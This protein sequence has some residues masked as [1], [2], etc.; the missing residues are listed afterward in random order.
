[1]LK[2]PF[3]WFGG[4]SRVAPIVWDRFGDVANYIE[5][6]FGSG[7]VLLGRPH[8]SG[9]TETINDADGFVANAWRAIKTHPDETADFADWPCNEN[10]LTARHIWLVGQ[11]KTLTEKLE[12]DPEYCDPKIAGWW[13]WG[14]AG[15]IG[16]GWCSGVGPWSSVDGKLV[17]LSNDGRGVNRQRVNL[18]NDGRGVN[19]QLVNLRNDGQG[20]N[21]K[22]AIH[23]WFGELSLRLR[24]VRVACGDWARVCGPAVTRAHSVASVGI[25]LDPPYS[26]EE[27]C[28]DLYAVEMKIADA[29]REYAIEVSRSPRVRVAL[30]G[31]E[32]EHTM[33]EGWEVFEWK[34]AGGYGSQGR[35]R[36]RENK[37]RE[38]IWFSPSCRK[39]QLG[40]WDMRQTEEID[41]EDGN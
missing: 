15:W 30:C 28:G 40:L 1:M 32:G 25:F 11:R 14:I 16:R 34:A 12:G 9:Q 35:E 37:V 27:R 26:H 33:P 36:G 19:R 10:D 20:V 31:Y 2:A 13:L 4:K 41:D 17:N 5:P 38:R 22:T 24:R 23:D 29:V 18:S 3:P 39:S 7:A 6:F 8:Y 21:R